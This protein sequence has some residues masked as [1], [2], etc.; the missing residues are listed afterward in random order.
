VAS[1]VIVNKFM[2]VNK[3]NQE[4]LTE[5]TRLNHFE[6]LTLSL[7]HQIT[8]KPHQKQLVVPPPSIKLSF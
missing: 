7:V 6:V 4:K 8:N 5:V 2:L 3:K 1:K